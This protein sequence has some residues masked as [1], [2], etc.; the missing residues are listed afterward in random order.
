MMSLSEPDPAAWEPAAAV[1]VMERPPEGRRDGAGARSDLHDT[2]I[3][4]VPHHHAA[5]VAR[6]APRR[7]CGN[8]GAILEDGLAGLI[9][10]GE[11]R[12]VDVDAHP[13]WL[14]RASVARWDG[15]HQ[16][17]P[18][19]GDCLRKELSSGKCRRHASFPFTRYAQGAWTRVASW[20]Q[21]SSRGLSWS[22]H[23]D[24]SGPHPWSRRR[25]AR[26]LPRVRALA[27]HRPVLPGV[28]AGARRAAGRLRAAA[29]TAAALA[30]RRR[31]GRLRGAAPARRRRVRNEAPLR[32]PG[33]PGPAPR[34]APRRTG[35]RRSAR[36]R[37]RPHA[38]RHAA[39]DEG[40]DRAL[41]RARLRRD[42]AVHHEPGRGRAL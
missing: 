33:L 30:R 34:A 15:I 23:G 2:T 18:T 4:T 7:F 20:P 5:R 26:P 38:P 42:R 21:A 8:V 13:R 19:R 41:P 35:Y 37:L 12:G 11:R 16:V 32:A 29:R 3:E 36:N 27:R 25:G 31:A 28:R 1:A 22:A 24:R 10:I 40:G 14:L 17:L 9:G 39:L 6:Q